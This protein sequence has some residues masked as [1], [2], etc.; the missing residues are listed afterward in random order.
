MSEE[1]LEVS[2][3]QYEKELES[4]NK[5][6]EEVDNLLSHRKAFQFLKWMFYAN[7]VVLVSTI[8]HSVLCYINETFTII[9]LICALVV[10]Y[11]NHITYKYYKRSN[12]RIAIINKVEENYN[13][14]LELLEYLIAVLNELDEADNRDKFVEDVGED[15]A[16]AILEYEMCKQVFAN[17]VREGYENE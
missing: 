10:L 17:A 6:K 12:D 3:E 11:F 1:L 15:L 8:T 14:C 4:F 5:V 2:C 7:T 13:R 9:T 16:L